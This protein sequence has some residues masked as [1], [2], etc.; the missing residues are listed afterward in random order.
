MNPA[1]A[2]PRAKN[3]PEYDRDFYQWTQH[4]AELLRQ[5][6][7]NDVDVPNLAEEVE[8]MGNTQKHALVSHLAILLMH[9]L[10]WKY[11]PGKRTP[12]WETTILVQRDE[13]A[14]LLEDSPSLR[15]ELEKRFNH[16]Y[17]R[18]RKMT[19]KETGLALAVFPTENPFTFAEVMNEDWLPQE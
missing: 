14:D 8:S 5:G 3:A 10:K 16:A 11:Q 6:R 1:V 19:A 15:S 18:A 13:V 2:N 7:L 17:Q 12:S 4:T 9:L